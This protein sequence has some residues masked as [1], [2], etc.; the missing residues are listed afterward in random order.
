MMSSDDTG[1]VVPAD[2]GGRRSGSVLGRAVVAD[3]LRG[4]DAVGALG[5]EHETNWRRGYLV[6]FRR[7]LEAGLASRQA[8]VTIARDGLH[9]LHRRMQYR[10]PDGREVPVDAMLHDPPWAALST[11]EIRGT[12]EPEAGFTLPFRG[13]R[14]SGDALARR[15]D[16][17]AEAGALEPS[18]ADRVRTVMAHPEWLR[19]D[20]Q[21]VAVL[22][23]DA[24]MGPLQ[25]LLRWGARVA[26]VDLPRPEVAASAGHRSRRGWN[27][28]GAR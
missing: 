22:G 12:G 4:V 16:S 7:V 26:A 5:A 11:V 8:A 13:E 27:P 15:L 28:A 9:A 18:A 17:W 25:A 23:A 3:A 24:E 19:L 2:P 21:T 6:H 14:L 20:G 1:V 10:Q